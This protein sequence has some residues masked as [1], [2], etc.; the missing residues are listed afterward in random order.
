MSF[1]SLMHHSDSQAN[2]RLLTPPTKDCNLW[3]LCSKRRK[4]A[5]RALQSPHRLFHISEGGLNPC[6]KGGG[7]CIALVLWVTRNELELWDGKL[8]MCT[9][10]VFFYPSCVDLLWFELSYT[11]WEP[12]CNL[13]SVWLSDR[14]GQTELLGEFPSNDKIQSAGMIP[15][16][17]KLR[18]NAGKALFALC[19]LEK[20]LPIYCA[21]SKP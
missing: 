1:W 2:F 20:I 16:A 18:S 21:I 14:R 5:K 7:L 6:K 9:R 8:Q 3:T 4:R 17:S 15:A 12:G 13:N 10:K 11:V 19:T